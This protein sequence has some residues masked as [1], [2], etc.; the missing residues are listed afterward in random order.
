[1]LIIVATLA[2]LRKAERGDALRYVNGGW[3]AALLAGVVT[4]LVAEHASDH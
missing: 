2:L 3:A 4:C 1:M